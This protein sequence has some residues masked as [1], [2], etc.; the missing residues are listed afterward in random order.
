VEEQDGQYGTGEAEDDISFGPGFIT[1]TRSGTGVRA[2]YSYLDLHG[3]LSGVGA[4]EGEAGEEG[5]PGGIQSGEEE[6][7][8]QDGDQGA[9]YD[10]VYWTCI[11]VPV[12]NVVAFALSTE[13]DLAVAISCVFSV[14]IFVLLFL[15]VERNKRVKGERQ[16][17]DGESR[18]RAHFALRPLRFQDGTPH[19]CAKVPTIR[20]SVTS[21]LALYLTQVQV[22]GDYL[23]LCIGPGRV[24]Y[25]LSQGLSKLYLIAWKQ[26]SIT[27]VSIHCLLNTSGGNG[28]G[29]GGG[30]SSWKI[31]QGTMELSI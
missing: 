13:L 8:D 6:N 23:L 19:P 4:G 25:R 11:K 9:D 22:L 18:T 24:N 30:D 5:A 26:G 10:R 15:I 7:G 3:C 27:L 1:A 14:P 20:F 17:Q 12:W 29:G 16:F 28:N 21:A 2:S 31:L